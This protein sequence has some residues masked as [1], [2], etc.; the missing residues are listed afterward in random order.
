MYLDG[1]ADRGTS[2]HRR[3]SGDALAEDEVPCPSH[4]TRPK[5]GRPE[6]DLRL[7]LGSAHDI[8]HLDEPRLASSY[9]IDRRPDRRSG[10]RRGYLPD[11][12]VAGTGDVSQRETCFCQLERR[13]GDGPG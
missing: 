3:T 1:D 7:V 8:G 4:R 13:L 2:R 11:D 12:L 9:N 6:R 10:A 5:T